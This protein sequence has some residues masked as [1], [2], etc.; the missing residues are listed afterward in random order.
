MV[1]NVARPAHQ[2]QQTRSWTRHEAASKAHAFEQARAKGSSERAFAEENDVPRTT[3]QHW[4][5]RRARIEVAPAVVAFFESPQ[6]VVLLERVVMAAHYV[7]TLMGHSGIRMVSAFLEHAGLDRFVGSS[8]GA[9]QKLSAELLDLVLD[10]EQQEQARLAANM[11]QKTITL[12]LDETFPAKGQCLVAME[13]VS[14]FILLEAYSDKRDAATWANSL[15]QATE[16]MKLHV[17]QITS[18]GAKALIRHAKDQDAHH[19]PDLFHVQ[20]EITRALGRP[21]GAAVHSAHESLADATLA[22]ENQQAAKLAYEQAPRRPGRPPSFDKRLKKG[23]DNVAHHQSALDTARKQKARYTAALHGISD[24]YHPYISETGAPRTAD[25]LAKELATQFTELDTLADGVSLGENALAKLNKAR[26]VMPKMVATLAFYHQQVQDRVQALKIPQHQ[27]DLLTNTW[28]PAA[29]LLSAA[30]KARTVEHREELRQ[31]ATTMMATHK[32]QW[33][34][35]PLEE[36]QQLDRIARDCA[37]IFQRS[38]SCVE[39]RNGRLALAEHARRQLP[40]RK[41]RSLTVM[42]NY[43]TQRSDGTTAAER[44]FGAPPQA[45]FGWLLERFS[46]VPRPARRREKAK[47]EIPVL[48]R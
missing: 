28:I 39:G 46:G 37:Q 32:A 16:G 1:M 48:C 5:A 18:D 40:E 47:N 11:P 15:N 26:R 7:M 34:G 35:L 10:Y 44:F 12:C 31:V 41:L 33:A 24:Q 8:Y 4:R 14:G 27:R 36:K 42:H 9:Q 23:A 3:L 20:Q 2:L 21:M 17:E 43:V 29:Y 45:L 6:G 13:P 19:S 22:L 25:A 30:A 38:S